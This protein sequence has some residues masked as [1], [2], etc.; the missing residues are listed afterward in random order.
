M[1]NNT[2]PIILYEAS[3]KYENAKIKKKNFGIFPQKR[4][5]KLNW[6]DK[7]CKKSSISCINDFDKSN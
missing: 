3:Q 6:S 5:I 7:V 4:G 1:S 2:T